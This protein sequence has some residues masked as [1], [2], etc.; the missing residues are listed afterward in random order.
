MFIRQNLTT[1]LNHNFEVFLNMKFPKM[2]KDKFVEVNTFYYPLHD[3]KEEEMEEALTL[4][5]I[6]DWED[7]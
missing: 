4:S 6:L 5:E 2:P 7:Q 3:D 1:T